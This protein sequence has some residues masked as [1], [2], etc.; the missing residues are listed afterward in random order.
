MYVTMQ[1]NT[2]YIE[3]LARLKLDLVGHAY[4]HLFAHASAL[5]L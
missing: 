3:A 1:T 2:K 5:A 4:A